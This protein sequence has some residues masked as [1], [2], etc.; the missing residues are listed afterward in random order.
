VDGAPVKVDG[1][2]VKVDGAPVNVDGVPVV[3]DGPSPPLRS[4][5][6]LTLLHRKAH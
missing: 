6:T 1:A 2:P 3:V 4:T 5:A